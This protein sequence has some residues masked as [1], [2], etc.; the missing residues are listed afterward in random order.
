[1]DQ[2][3][4]EG[5]PQGLPRVAEDKLPRKRLSAR[6]GTF[7]QFGNIPQAYRKGCTRLTSNIG[8]DR[9][10]PSIFTKTETNL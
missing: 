2:G 3:R 1:V 8:F 5:K 9:S 6:G 4:C 7:Y 10:M